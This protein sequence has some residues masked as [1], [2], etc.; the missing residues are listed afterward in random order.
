MAV[1]NSTG[2]LNQNS[3]QTAPFGLILD[4]DEISP[5]PPQKHWIQKLP[6]TNSAFFWL[7]IRPILMLGL[8]AVWFWSQDEMLK[9]FWTDWADRR[10]IMFQGQKMHESWWELFANY[11]GHWLSFPTPTHMHICSNHSSGYR[12]FNTATC[13]V[14]RTAKKWNRKW[15]GFGIGFGQ[16][17]DYNF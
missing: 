10:T 4:F 1:G 5:W 16:W 14:Q 17:W 2:L 9:T 8:I 12:C 7:L 11:V 15:F 3:G 6:L 13:G